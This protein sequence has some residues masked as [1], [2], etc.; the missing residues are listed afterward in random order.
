MRLYF[1]NERAL[2]TASGKLSIFQCLVW[3][4]SCLGCPWS[5]V[6]LFL[7]Y[8]DVGDVSWTSAIIDHEVWSSPVY[9][10][11][12]LVLGNLCL[13]TPWLSDWLFA[14]AVACF[15]TFTYEYSPVVP[16]LM[17]YQ[18][19]GNAFS[20]NAKKFK[21]AKKS[22]FFARLIAWLL[23]RL[24]NKSLSTL[25]LIIFCIMFLEIIRFLNIHML[26]ADRWQKQPQKSFLLA[27]LL[28]RVSR[29]WS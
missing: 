23:V 25:L 21:K 19:V 16:M 18:K 22:V 26:E 6:F 7:D 14:C 9:M 4:L 8:T 13:L 17:A 2:I 3:S 27:W 10:E 24:F 1:V 28:G 11:N 12:Y 15:L 20:Q 29:S 5:K